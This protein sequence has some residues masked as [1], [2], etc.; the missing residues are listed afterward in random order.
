MRDRCHKCNFSLISLI[1][2]ARNLYEYKSGH[3]L[4]YEKLT[5]MLHIKIEEYQL[6]DLKTLYNDIFG[7]SLVIDTSEGTVLDLIYSLCKDIISN[8]PTKVS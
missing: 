8:Y 1:P 2:V 7:T 4:E 5:A 3:T 6:S